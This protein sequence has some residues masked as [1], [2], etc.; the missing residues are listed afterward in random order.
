MNNIEL[1]QKIK[2]LV[3][4]DSY[5]DLRLAMMNFDNEYKHTD[6]YKMTKLSLEKIVS[7]AR[8]HYA[9]HLDGLT[10]KIQKIIDNLSLDNV[11]QLLDQMTNTFQ[12]ENKEIG[13]MLDT[14]KE[15]R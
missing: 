9:S 13:E 14:V 12:K 8:L 5:I 3:A 11:N 7:E 6:F 15:L 10:N 2:E 1:E 4:I